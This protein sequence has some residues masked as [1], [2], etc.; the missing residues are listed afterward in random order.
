MTGI[1]SWGM[2]GPKVLWACIF[3]NVQF[4]RPWIDSAIVQSDIPKPPIFNPKI[5]SVQPKSLS[6]RLKN[7]LTIIGGLVFVS[8]VFFCLTDTIKFIQNY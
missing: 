3:V 8:I 1:V 7:K 4:Y 5:V 6:T 2:G